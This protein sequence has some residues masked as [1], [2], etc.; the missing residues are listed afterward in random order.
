MYQKGRP[1]HLRT[2]PIPVYFLT[3][4]LLCLCILTS[5]QSLQ[6][7]EI[8]GTVY[9]ADGLTPYEDVWVS[10]LLWTN[11]VWETS[12]STRTDTAGVYA[13]T[14]SDPGT[15]RLAFDGSHY[16]PD[17]DDLLAAEDILLVPGQ[18]NTGFDMSMV[19]HG[20]GIEGVV[21]SATDGSPITNAWIRGFYWNGDEYPRSVG[22][23]SDTNGFFEFTELAAGRYR[24]EAQ[25]QVYFESDSLMQGTDIVV[26]HSSVVTNLI[27]PLSEQNSA[28]VGTLSNAGRTAFSDEWAS[29]Y[30]HTGDDW[31]W[32]GSAPVNTEGNYELC[33]LQPG[34][35][36]VAFWTHDDD[37][38][39]QMYGDGHGE[40]PGTGTNLLLAAGEV[41]TNDLFEISSG[42]RISGT[43]STNVSVFIMAAYHEVDDEW[44]EVG[45]H[46]ARP[47]TF[48][49]PVLN[50]GIYRIASNTGLTYSNAAT[51]ETGTD[52]LVDGMGSATNLF[53]D[54]DTASI[55]GRVTA[56][57]GG[58]PLQGIEVSAQSFSVGRWSWAGSSRTNA[59]GE[60]E[61]SGLGPGDYRLS[62]SHPQNVYA[63]LVYPDATSLE[64]G[65][66]VRLDGADRTNLDVDLSLSGGV[67]GFVRN[68]QDNSP[69]FG[70][71]V[72]ALRNDGNGNWIEESTAF[73]NMQGM[74]QLA[75]LHEGVYRIQYFDWTSTFEYQVFSNATSLADG[76]DVL[77]SAGLVRGG[78]DAMLSAPMQPLSLAVGSLKIDG[79]KL[80][81]SPSSM[82]ALGTYFRLETAAQVEGPWTVASPPAY[83]LPDSDMLQRPIQRELEFLRVVPWP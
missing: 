53:F 17:V 36:Q 81:Y 59:A 42:Y 25:N 66:D 57:T 24:L 71:Q 39:R 78:I 70:V 3:A 2:S 46:Y 32:S 47:N 52:I 82:G 61:L 43:I 26:P 75:G 72:F 79:Q 65:Q 41:V 7:G 74:Y 14:I 69:I 16:Y 38:P 8:S 62:F 40:L 18:T 22:V 76:N 35:Y 54:A 30:K 67:R 73:S 11:G 37:F 21:V 50:T 80:R 20:G 51:V 9:E 56:N 19:W 33:C 34:T 63:M 23:R 10:T 15:Y 29:A 4:Q 49:F 55:S 45:G 1:L 5:I 60:Y 64:M 44:Q 6:A 77:V 28:I 27:F 83:L 68:A 12:R 58:T 13:L 48:S 31:I